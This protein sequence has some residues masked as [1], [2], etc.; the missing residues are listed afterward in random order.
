MQSYSKV[1]LVYLTV[2][3]SAYF[4]WEF[5]VQEW[6]TSGD[7]QIIRYDLIILPILLII[8]GYSVYTFIKKQ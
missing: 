2:I 6:A 5:Q 8:T 4:L 1:Y 3:W 7:G